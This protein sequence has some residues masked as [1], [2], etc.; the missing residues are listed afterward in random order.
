[1]DHLLEFPLFQQTCYLA[2]LIVYNDTAEDCVK[3]QE[4]TTCTRLDC[5]RHLHKLCLHNPCPRYGGPIPFLGKPAV[6]PCRMAGPAP[7]KSRGRRVKSWPDDTHKHT[8]VIWISDLSH[9]QINKKQTSTRCN[10]THWVHLKC[11]HIQQ[12]QYKPDWRYTIHTPTQNVTTTPSTYNTTPHHK[13]TTTHPLTNNNKP[14][15]KNIV[16]L[17]ININDIRNKIEELKN[18]VHSTQPD[19][20]T[21]QETKLTHNAKTPQIPHYTTIRT[22]REHKQGG[23]SSH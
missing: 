9:K 11:T 7:N 6:A 20:I 23:G 3:L 15:D 22:D 13:Q 4:D 19:I 18:L 12:R 14:K 10:H 21:I 1:M 5:F 8:P 17:Q 2:D 16:I